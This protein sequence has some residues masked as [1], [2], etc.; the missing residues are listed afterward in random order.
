MPLFTIFPVGIYDI[1]LKSIFYWCSAKSYGGHMLGGYPIGRAGRFKI[2]GSQNKNKSW[3][4]EFGLS[5]SG[6]LRSARLVTLASVRVSR[7]EGVEGGTSNLA[8]IG[9]VAWLESGSKATGKEA[10]G[11]NKFREEK[12]KK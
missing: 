2:L 4:C 3:I 7:K 9:N 5:S 11:S 10:L 1:D 8:D 12:N 6:T